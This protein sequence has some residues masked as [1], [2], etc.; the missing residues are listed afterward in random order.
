MSL[1]TKWE[2][3]AKQILDTPKFLK[4]GTKVIVLPNTPPREVEV[5]GRFGKRKVYIVETKCYGFI[6][7]TPLQLTRIVEAFDGDYSNAVTVEL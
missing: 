6:Y 5:E 2:K 7:V 3:T 1:Q 4:R